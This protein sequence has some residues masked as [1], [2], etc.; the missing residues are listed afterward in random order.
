ML[1]GPRFRW[2]RP[3]A[4]LGLFGVFAFALTMV[5]LVG[6]Y[7]A[8]LLL[9]VADPSR[10][11][12]NTL[13]STAVGVPQFLALNFSLILLIPSVFFAVWIA[14]GVRP[15]FLSSVVGRLRWRWL[16]R[17]L[18]VLVPLW[19]GYL[20]LS[21]LVGSSPSARPAHWP[22]LLV[23]VLVLTPLQSAAEEYTFRGMVLQVVG[24]WFA[25]PLAALIVPTVLSVVLFAAAHGSPDPYILGDIGGVALA[26]CLL[27]WRT[28]GLEAGICLH[29]VNNVTLFALGL[30]YG[31]FEDSFV[32]R[33]TTS[34]PLALA[35]GLVIDA[36]AVLVVLWQAK[37][38]RLDR[39][40]QPT[41]VMPT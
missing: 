24:S 37:R 28:G 3:L 26:N 41:A 5:L 18:L 2:W 12:V 38:A 11:V 27:A 25:R 13:T 9:R 23:L 22:V 7:I 20:G 15:G 31:G 40:Y 32:R 39:L 6:Y 19:V 17:C 16:A 10:W 29:A 35:I 36:V 21:V 14:Y 34:T 4:A 30:T 8:A 33:S 1:R